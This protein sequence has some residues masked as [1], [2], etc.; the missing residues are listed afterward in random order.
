[1]KF[2]VQRSCASALSPEDAGSLVSGPRRSL[3]ETH[4]RCSSPSSASREASRPKCFWSLELW[5]FHATSG[6]YPRAPTVVM[7]TSM[8]PL[9]NT[10]TRVLLVHPPPAPRI[11]DNAKALPSNAHRYM[12]SDLSL[13]LEQTVI[14]A[15]GCLLQS[16]ASDF[17]V[18]D[19]AWPCVCS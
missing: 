8:L 5:D 17:P 19:G 10:A 2:L 6:Q 9:C 4:Y 7:W 14:G 16:T 13:Q 12:A 15:Y 18:Y 11:L 3:S 1:M